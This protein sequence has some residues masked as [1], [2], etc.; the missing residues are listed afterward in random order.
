M[1]ESELRVRN[2]VQVRKEY[3]H[4]TMV[5]HF[6]AAATS[7]RDAIAPVQRRPIFRGAFNVTFPGKAA[8]TPR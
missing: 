5:V 8:T 4:T 1:K 2:V 6:S 3:V 7:E